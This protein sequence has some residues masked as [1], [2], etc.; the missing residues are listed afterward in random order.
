MRTTGKWLTWSGLAIVLVTVIAGIALAINGFGKLTDVVDQSFTVDGPTSYTASAGEVLYLYG[1]NSSTGSV[2]PVC[3]VTGPAPVQPGPL[4]TGSL[5][6]DGTDVSSF[7][8]YRFTTAGQYTIQCDTPGIVA[9]PELPVGGIVSGAGGVLLAVFGG[10]L[11]AVL[12]ILGIVL[13]V[14]GANRAQRADPPPYPG[15]YGEPPAGY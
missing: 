1:P 5:T 8:S 9:G 12:L 13:W 2:D 7:K 3:E 15:G 4:R 14:V 6:F 11:G 10:G